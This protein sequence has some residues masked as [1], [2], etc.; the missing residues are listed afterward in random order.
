MALRPGKATVTAECGGVSGRGTLIVTPERVA[1]LRISPDAVEMMVGDSL[2]LAAAPQ[3]ARG[4]ELAGRSVRWESESPDVAEVE[5]GGLLWGI[6]PGSATVTAR[7]EGKEASARV[8]VMLAPVLALDLLPSVVSL[9]EGDSIRLHAIPRGREGR[10]LGSRPVLWSSSQGSVAEVDEEGLVH[11]VEEGEA[12]VL[13]EC[14][15]L[16]ASARVVVLPAPVASVELP[17]PS[18]TLGMGES[19]T[20]VPV[21]KGRDGRVLKDRPL[22]WSSSRPEV[23]RVDSD[24]R[25]TALAEG[26][27]II[28]ADCEK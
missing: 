20:L 21:L 19:R 18:I 2:Q 7:C 5:E 3:D 16:E 24:G 17:E 1:S 12:T 27:A 25:L 28:T 23:A 14:Q 11:A 22:A 15:G 4:R 13:A 8:T 9:N 10:E 6:R 26:T